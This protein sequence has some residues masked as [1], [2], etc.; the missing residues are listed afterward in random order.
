MAL[1]VAVLKETA[2]GERRVALVPGVAAK[3][4]KLGVDVRMQSGAGDAIML[5]D[6]L[7]QGVGFAEDATSLVRDA[8]VVLCVQPPDPGIARAI[9]P[10]AV[11][12]SFMFGHRHPELVRALR[13]GEDHTRALKSLEDLLRAI[14]GVVVS[15]E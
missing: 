5:P 11:L 13:A 14:S 15:R 8:D 12:I 10:G 9:R 3:F 2:A 7:Y 6:R 4:I 1:T